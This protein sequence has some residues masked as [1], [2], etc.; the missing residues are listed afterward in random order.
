MSYPDP[1]LTK[2]QKQEWERLRHAQKARNHRRWAEG[3]I[4]QPQ[5]FDV[6]RLASPMW[7][8][9]RALHKDYIKAGVKKKTTKA[10]YFRRARTEWES[11]WVRPEAYRMST[12][13]FLN[14]GDY[15]PE[16]IKDFVNPGLPRKD[17]ITG[18]A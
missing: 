14:L 3:T 10:G 2:E 16:D 17:P 13:Q 15:K 12:K 18:V 1:N 9:Y 11:K 4:G 8:Q 5:S 6:G 7:H